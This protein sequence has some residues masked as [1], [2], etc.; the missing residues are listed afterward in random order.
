MKITNER[1]EE[2]VETS[3]PVSEGSWRW[4]TTR[5][6]VIEDGGK[7]WAFTVRF[8]VEE[9]MQKG[10]DYDAREVVRTERMIVEWKPVPKPPVPSFPPVQNA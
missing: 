3:E 5:T 1:A 10:G 2:I 6:Y 9:G 8:H 7:H 4:G